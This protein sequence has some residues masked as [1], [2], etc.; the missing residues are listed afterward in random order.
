MTTANQSHIEIRSGRLARYLHHAKV[1]ANGWMEARMQR[2][3]SAEIRKLSRKERHDLGLNHPDVAPKHGG[4]R[5][6]HRMHD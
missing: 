1:I 2:L 6:K 4:V 3:T 5:P